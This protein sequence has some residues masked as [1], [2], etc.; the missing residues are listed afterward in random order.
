MKFSDISEFYEGDIQIIRDC[1]FNNLYLVGKEFD[2]TKKNVSFVG[3]VKY[4]KEFLEYDIKGVICTESVAESLE[5][6]Y[7]GGIIIAENPKT[8]FFE[9][10][11][12]L[13]EQKVKW[14]E[15]E[16][17]PSAIIHSSAII[18]DR[19][20]HIGKNVVIYSNVTIKEGSYIGDNSIIREGCV[21]GGPAFY[22]FGED[23][24]RTLVKSTGT[25]KIGKNVELHSNVIVEKGVMYG[26]T[27]IDD[28]TKI[29][30][31][32]VVGHD[33]KISK[34]CTI[35]GN[36]DL[37][38]GVR[39][40]ENTFLGVLVAV[41]PNVHI[42]KNAKLSS[43]AVVTKDVPDDEHFSGNFAIEHRK[44]IS[45]IKEISK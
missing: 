24:N 35:A 39:I 38:G 44:Y 12:Y 6:A 5:G 32:V 19:G 15:N 36:G 13:A 28:N 20:V 27:L 7:S 10:H 1:E 21:I 43:G 33:V 22:Y 42:G 3:D 2:S 26:E 11:N 17:E 41:A 40:G 45:H 34:N 4:M 8:T 30:N 37:A 14:E 9:I 25:V 31:C 18:A 29:D 23:D 16:I